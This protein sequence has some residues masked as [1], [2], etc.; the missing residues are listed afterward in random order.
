MILV[1]GASGTI[2]RV[3]VAQLVE[4]GV[5]VRAMTRDPEKTRTLPGFAGAEVVSG[6]PAQPASLA[7]VF[8]G[9]DQ[10]LL[11]P[12]SG[13][14]W[15]QGEQNL[16]EAAKAAGVRY[17]VKV[18][19]MGADPAE[20]S[21][22]LAF[23]SEGESRLK[24][25]GMPFTVLRGNSFMQNFLV[26][27]AAS[28]RGEGAIYQCTGDVPTALV[29][30]RDIAD[31]AVALL[32]SSL[33]QYHGQICELTGPEAL[34]YSQAAAKIGAATGRTVRY[35][36]VPPAAYRQALMGFGLP[37]WAADEVVNIYGRGFY[38]EGHGARLNS[39]VSDI[40]G[41]AARSFDSFVQEHVSHF[42][43]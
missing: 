10:V 5:P 16:I 43:P 30:T 19:A 18:S 32:T 1:V 14:N 7:A 38:R 35:V 24:E 22:S 41:R 23:H 33:P 3:V 21:M 31:V 6:D 13:P 42:T 12:P 20:P 39:T 40:L 25:S 26:F 17:I 15:N 9:V 2:G 28:I 37:D 4:K 27:Y 34:S 36:D 11:I 8:A 29:D